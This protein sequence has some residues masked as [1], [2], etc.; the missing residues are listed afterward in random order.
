MPARRSQG[1]RDD[2]ESQ[3]TAAVGDSGQSDSTHAAL[4]RRINSLLEEHR[5]DEAL[6]SIPGKLVMIP[7]FKNAQCV[8]WM[9]LGRYHEAVQ[10]L[11]QICV[12]SHLS[13]RNDIPVHFQSNFATALLLSGNADGY[14]AILNEIRSREHPAVMKLVSAVERWKATLPWTQRLSWKVG[15]GGANSVSL[16]IPPG[17]VPP[18]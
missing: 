5:P 10:G 12:T 7:V 4:L 11:R 13:L 15:L 9:R 17:D 14:R 18:E 16:D 6:A 1:S 8:C 3:S 2:S